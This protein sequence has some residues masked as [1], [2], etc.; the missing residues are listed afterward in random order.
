MFV[1]P[2]HSVVW[3]LFLA[4]IPVILSL[5]IFAGVRRQRRS[6]HVQWLLW[7]PML[8]VWLAFLPNTC[9]LITEWRH[10]LDDLLRSPNTYFQSR[11][12]H[13]EM[14]QLMLGSAFYICYSGS[15]LICFYLS[16]YPLDMLFNPPWYVR[17][18]FFFL[19]SLGVYLGLVDRFNSWQV[20]HL[21][22][23]VHA[24]HQAV[25]RPVL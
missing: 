19:I 20:F 12:S 18:F 8:I 15:G 2:L 1:R 9:Y 13:S 11:H 23:I 5:I 21:R 24:A 16:I 6:G 7:G 17:P 3:N 10:Y 25:E 14:L 22:A 4:V